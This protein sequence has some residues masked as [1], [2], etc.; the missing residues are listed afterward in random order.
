MQV[1]FSSPIHFSFYF[2]GTAPVGLE[3]LAETFE[4]EVEV[5]VIDATEE[6]R[7]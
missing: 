3:E 2:P 7:Q 1:T 5:N 6:Y 4:D